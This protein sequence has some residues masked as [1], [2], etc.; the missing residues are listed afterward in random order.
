MSKSEKRARR[1]KHIG[2]T[3]ISQP[4][5]GQLNHVVGGVDIMAKVPSVDECGK[6]ALVKTANTVLHLA[7]EPKRSGRSVPPAFQR[8]LVHV[9]RRFPE[10][11]V[12]VNGVEE[13]VVEKPD[14]DAVVRV[15]AV[16]ALQ[17]LEE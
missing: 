11:R 9:P 16:I 12:E 14:V 7:L 6:G 3:W 17:I 1:Q 10:L 15:E 5:L 8:K 2:P 4:L 13:E